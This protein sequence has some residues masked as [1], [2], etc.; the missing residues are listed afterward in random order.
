MIIPPPLNTKERTEFDLNDLK[1]IFVRCQTLGISKDINIRKRI[2]VLKEC[3]GREE[4]M[5]E[6]LDLSLF[7]EEKRKE[8]ERMRESELMN[9]MFECYRR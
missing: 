2:C 6:F 3:A 5:K 7:V 4:F 1:S 8:M 9:C